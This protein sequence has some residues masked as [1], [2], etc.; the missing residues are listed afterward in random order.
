MV[1]EYGAIFALCN[2]PKYDRVSQF[3]AHY[4]CIRVDH[5]AWSFGELTE[6]CTK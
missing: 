2:V 5:A 1:K 3:S 6:A 4:G